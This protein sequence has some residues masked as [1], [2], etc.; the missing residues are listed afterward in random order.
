MKARTLPVRTGI[1]P[2]RWLIAALIAWTLHVAPAGAAWFYLY[3]LTDIA[4]CIG[5]DASRNHMVMA[6]GGRYLCVAQH[7]YQGDIAVSF[8]DFNTMDWTDQIVSDP[9]AAG[10]ASSPALAAGDDGKLYVV[11][12]REVAGQPAAVEYRAWTAG[13]DPGQ[14][15]SRIELLGNGQRPSI[16]TA[17][18]GR[19][20]AAWIDGN[21]LVAYHKEN[22][23]VTVQR[24]AGPFAGCP[25]IFSD[26]QTNANILIERGRNEI[27]H[28]IRRNG[29]WSAP[30][31]LEAMPACQPAVAEDPARGV[32]HAVWCRPA[33]AANQ[34]QRDIMYSTFNGQAWTAPLPVTRQD[35]PGIRE[36]TP[37]LSVASNGTV[38]VVWYFND[39]DRPNGIRSISHA[40]IGNQRVVTRDVDTVGAT[41]DHDPHALDVAADP[42][43]GVHV[44]WDTLVSDA[45]PNSMIYYARQGLPK[46]TSALPAKFLACDNDPSRVAPYRTHV[47]LRGAGFDWGFPF[48]VDLIPSAPPPH[49]PPEIF[50]GENRIRIVGQRI[51]NAWTIDLTI[52]IDP[53][54]EPWTYDVVFTDL[55]YGIDTLRRGRVYELTH[56]CCPVDELF[57][58]FKATAWTGT[59][60]IVTLDRLRSFRDEWMSQSA[61]GTNL[62]ALLYRNAYEVSGILARNPQ[63]ARRAFS[64]IQTLGPDLSQVTAKGNP[65][66]SPLDPANLALIRPATIQEGLAII[67]IIRQGSSKSLQQVIA[68][69][70]TKAKANLPR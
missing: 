38:H 9:N 5:L 40:T 65:A 15:W 52:E 18:G 62:T 50:P 26:A 36:D 11:W 7:D 12:Q 35:N 37:N 51:V 66:K 41:E 6:P 24:I 25:Q 29:Q 33:S 53:K 1:D 64:F 28:L 4:D 55:Y 30:Q 54:F 22:N 44:V 48:S 68:G 17:P 3:A 69:W 20:L 27:V 70:A 57:A 21:Q 47:L 49:L 58:L 56:E 23:A 39:N 8:L 10:G 45:N 43:G 31:P 63:L 61:D 60:S 42:Y 34:N 2:K 59:S 46:V 19:L 13:N 32:T 16:D 14:G 67:D